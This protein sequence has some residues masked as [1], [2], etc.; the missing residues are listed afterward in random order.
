MLPTLIGTISEHGNI[1]ILILVNNLTLMDN[2]IRHSVTFSTST[3]LMNTLIVK[4]ELLLIITNFNT[5][6]KPL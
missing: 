3:E 1:A 5:I 4:V 6:E 2:P